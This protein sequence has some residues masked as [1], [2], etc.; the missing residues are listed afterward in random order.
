MASMRIAR[1][2]HSVALLL[3]DGR[4]LAGGGGRADPESSVDE[5]NFEIYSPPYLFSGVRPSITST[6]QVVGHGQT[7]FLETPDAANITDVNWIRLPSVTHAFDQNQRLN[8]LS[9]QQAAGGLQ[10]TAP[11]NPKVAPPGHYML[12][13]LNATGVPSVAAIVQVL[14]SYAFKINA[15]HSGAWFNTATSGQGQF[16]D[17]EPEEKFMFVSWFTYTDAA[18]ANP[19][20]QRWLTA[21]GNYTGNT[22]HLDLFETL[23]PIKYI[24]EIP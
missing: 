9:F 21:Q 8:R 7:F 23:A 15:G 2:Y 3:P 20:E 6:P 10:V 14:V 1:V 18:S 12:F 5:R 17:V 13:I 4:V 24:P 16:I 22:A 19:L 11:L